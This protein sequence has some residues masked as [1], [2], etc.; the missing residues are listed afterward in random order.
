MG[1]FA[2]NHFKGAAG[3]VFRSWNQRISL[4][5]IMKPKTAAK[6]SDN[7]NVIST[8]IHNSMKRT[9]ST[10]NVTKMLRLRHRRMA[11]NLC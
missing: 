11:I 3:S 8:M 1:I 10:V 6:P 5:S 7:P 4:Y 2:K 9:I